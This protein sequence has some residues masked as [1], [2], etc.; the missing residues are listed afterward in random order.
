MPWW[1]TALTFGFLGGAAL[2][3]DG[4]VTAEGNPIR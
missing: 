1:M 4:A 2:G 3:L